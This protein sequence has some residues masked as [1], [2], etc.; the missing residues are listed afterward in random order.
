VCPIRRIRERCRSHRSNQFKPGTGRSQTS[1]GLLRVSLSRRL[2]NDQATRAV[3]CPTVGVNYV[4]SVV[5]SVCLCYSPTAPAPGAGG[6][7]FG[8]YIF[9]RSLEGV[10]DTGRVRMAIMTRRAWEP[11]I[12]AAGVSAATWSGIQAW[13]VWGA[14]GELFQADI[15]VQ[16][17]TAGDGSE[18]VAVDTDGDLIFDTW[19]H[20]ENGRLVEMVFDDDQ[21]GRPDRRRFFDADGSVERTESLAA[22]PT[23]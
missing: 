15:R 11:F 22:G 8:S 5:N 18:V 6:P 12:V 1:G 3:G 14:K 21:D 19:S 17:R 4:I 7:F 10:A 9:V 13:T 20:F 23:P 2:R 16:S